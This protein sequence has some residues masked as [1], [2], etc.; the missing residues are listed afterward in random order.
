MNKISVSHTYGKVQDNTSR[1]DVVVK[2]NKVLC[3]MCSIWHENNSFCQMPRD[4]E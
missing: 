2:G 3:P 1:N 4:G